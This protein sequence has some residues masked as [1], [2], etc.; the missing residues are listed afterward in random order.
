MPTNYT[1]P[2]AIEFEYIVEDQSHK[3]LISCD[4]QGTPVA[5][6]DPSTVTLETKDTVGVDMQTAVQAYIDEVVG[7]YDSGVSFI[8]YTLWKYTA[9]SE[10]RTFITSDTLGDVGLSGGPSRLAG[11]TTLSFRT[12][13]GGI[14]KL[15]YLETIFTDDNQISLGGWGNANAIAIVAMVTATNTWFLAKDTSYPISALRASFGENE[16][17]FKKRYR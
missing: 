9:L 4:T 13:E 5:G 15:V 3:Q 11:Q 16:R 8:G 14:F 6:C 2:Y 12:Q 7:F 1:G 10:V 17:V